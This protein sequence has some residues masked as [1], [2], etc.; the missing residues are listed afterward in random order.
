M[1]QTLIEW[2]WRRVVRG[3]LTLAQLQFALDIGAVVNGEEVIL[4]GFTF[5]PWIGCSK[6]SP[7][8]LHCYAAELDLRRFS[9]TLGEATKEAPIV[10]W[11]KGAPR[12]RTSEATWKNPPK[13]NRQAQ[14]L[15]T[16]LRV[17]CASLADWLDDEVPLEW[18]ADL[19]SL[20]RSTPHL[21][22]IFVSKRP[23]NWRDRMLAIS[24]GLF[25]CDVR[26]FARDWLNGEAPR[27]VWF[28]VSTEDQQRADERIPVMFEISAVVHGISAE[29]LLGPVDLTRWLTFF[30]TVGNTDT[31]TNRQALNWVI[32]GGESGDDV[33][34]PDG[35]IISRIRPMNP[36]WARSLRDQCGAAGVPY[37]H[38]QWGEWLPGK[39][40]RR[41]GK[42]ICEPT[43]TGQE[44]G[45][46][47]WTNSRAPAVYLWDEADHYWTH[48]SA[49]VG[50]AEAGKLLDGREHNAT[51][52]TDEVAV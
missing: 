14:A 33:K 43:V 44:I 28:I 29:P 23:E 18:L 4:P 34:T 30:K 51:P 24:D 1:G 49:R 31:I 3:S 52:N 8:C 45:R 41:K 17:F 26:W 21:D 36:N 39:F 19:L 38:K 35:K 46:I 7:G 11:G 13:W 20:V 16:R 37:F 9:K 15:G 12:W 48:A 27:N 40:D 2:T 50:K 10:H 25:G 22:W 47:F 32:V 42:M 5:N 6:V